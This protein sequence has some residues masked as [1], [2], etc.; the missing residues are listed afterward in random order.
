MARHKGIPTGRKE[1]R[2]ETRQI[3][4]LEALIATAPLGKPSY[5]S[6]VRQA[7][8]DFIDRQILSKREVRQQVE[9]YLRDTG[10]VVALRGVKKDSERR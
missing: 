3:D 10:K 1:A 8:D 9:S 4:Y 2:L 6:L 7:V 5:V